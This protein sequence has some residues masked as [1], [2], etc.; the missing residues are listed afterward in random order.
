M[1]IVLYYLD[2]QGGMSRGKMVF[3]PGFKHYAKGWHLE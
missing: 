2:D 1:S 3:Y